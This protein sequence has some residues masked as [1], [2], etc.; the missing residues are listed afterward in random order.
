[1]QCNAHWGQ[2]QCIMW[3]LYSVDEKQGLFLHFLAPTALHLLYIQELMQLN[4][5]NLID[6]C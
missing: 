5:F 1:M 4:R 6:L 2:L 3:K